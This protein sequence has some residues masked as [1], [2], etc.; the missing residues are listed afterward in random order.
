MPDA[1]GDDASDAGA[2]GWEDVNDGNADEDGSDTS[3]ENGSTDWQDLD[4]MRRIYKDTGEALR[5]V[6]HDAVDQ[7]LEEY[8]TFLRDTANTRAKANSFLDKQQA[9]LAGFVEQVQNQIERNAIQSP[10]TDQ[11]TSA[12]VPKKSQNEASG[13]DEGK[14]KGKGKDEDEDEDEGK[15]KG[16]KRSADAFTESLPIRVKP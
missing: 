10:D 16:K 13:K 2:T 4:D 1:G 5:A 3:S 11:A 12:P 15:C 8:R 6:D 9:I 7:E 14:G